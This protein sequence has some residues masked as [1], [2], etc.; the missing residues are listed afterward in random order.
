MPER[1][2]PAMTMH[3]LDRVISVEDLMPQG[4]QVRALGPRQ[5]ALP[6]LG[7]SKGLRVLAAA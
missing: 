1:P 5:Y 2:A 7:M 6:A 3:D 4:T